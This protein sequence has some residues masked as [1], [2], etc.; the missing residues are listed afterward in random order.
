MSQVQQ[1][2]SKYAL[3]GPSVINAYCVAIFIVEKSVYLEGYEQG[4]SPPTAWA[5]TSY[6]ESER[7]RERER[8]YYDKTVESHACRQSRKTCRLPAQPSPR[9]M[10]DSPPPRHTGPWWSLVRTAWHWWAGTV[11]LASHQYLQST[12][13]Q[14]K[15]SFLTLTDDIIEND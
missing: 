10:V 9:P 4:P 2:S 13:P 3:M 12:D 14:S 1:S 7:E 15:E 5:T 11:A 6:S 8:E